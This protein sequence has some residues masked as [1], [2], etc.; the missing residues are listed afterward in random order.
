[1]SACGDEDTGDDTQGCIC[2]ELYAPVCGE[3]GVTYDNDCYADCE[4]VS[5]TEGA[6]E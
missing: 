3:D 2:Y 6:C 5:F 1:M 4:G